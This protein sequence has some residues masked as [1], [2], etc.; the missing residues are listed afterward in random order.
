[1][2]FVLFVVMFY[3]VLSELSGAAVHCMV[4]DAHHA[5]VG[6]DNDP[7]NL[8]LLSE[9]GRVL[10][11][12]DDPCVL[13]AVIALVIVLTVAAV[14]IAGLVGVGGDNINVA[15]LNAAAAAAAAGSAS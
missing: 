3:Q 7:L 15:Y 13:L 1:M 10:E 5:R 9:L 2:A 8:A 11:F 4:A 6:Q 12:G 14:K